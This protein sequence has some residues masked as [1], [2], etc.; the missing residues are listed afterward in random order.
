MC[1]R[2]SV[3][4]M[5]DEKEFIYCQAQVQV[6]FRSGPDLDLDK[7]PGL[8]IKFGMPPT[9]HHHHHQQAILRL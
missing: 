3:T 1:D 7:R 5:S 6:R 2:Y 8:Y 9:H 4:V